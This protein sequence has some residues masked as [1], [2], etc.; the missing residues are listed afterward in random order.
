MNFY[1]LPTDSALFLFSFFKG[2][3]YLLW[4]IDIGFSLIWLIKP[5]LL[6]MNGLSDDRTV[7]NCF[8]L[9]A[10]FYPGLCCYLGETI[11]GGDLL[12]NTD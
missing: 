7:V 5:I 9:S 1:Y 2:R 3:L 11:G 4:R 12:G 8:G 10:T 6:G